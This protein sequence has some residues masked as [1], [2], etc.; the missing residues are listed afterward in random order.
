[1]NIN[2]AVHL[3][4]IIYY[5]LSKRIDSILF[6]TKVFKL[7]LK[8]VSS[9]LFVERIQYGLPGVY[10]ALQKVK[11]SFIDMINMIKIPGD[12]EKKEI[13]DWLNF[14]R[15]FSH[16]KWHTARKAYKIIGDDKIYSNEDFVSYACNDDKAIKILCLILKIHIQMWKEDFKDID[17]EK[18]VPILATLYNVSDFENKKPHAN[19]LPGGSVLDHIYDGNYISGFNF[20]ERVNLTY[21]SENMKSFI[22]TVESKLYEN[23]K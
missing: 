16:I 12:G 8:L 13:S 4:G 11:C 6:Y 17:S 21:H 3:E 9:L 18:G 20:A 19:P 14:S 1:M 10:S 15:G 22:K 5:Q 7:D 23:A 2:E